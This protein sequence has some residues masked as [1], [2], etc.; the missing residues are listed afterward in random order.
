MSVRF[1][2]RS[3]FLLFSVKFITFSFACSELEAVFVATAL[4]ILCLAEVKSSS[5]AGRLCLSQFECLL[6]RIYATCG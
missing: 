2:I 6:L 1:G 5:I 3:I 4:R